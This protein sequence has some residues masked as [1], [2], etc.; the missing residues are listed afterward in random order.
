MYKDCS[1]CFNIFSAEF[2]ESKLACDVSADR[3]MG[4]LQVLDLSAVCVKNISDTKK[5]FDCQVQAYMAENT[6]AS[7]YT[8]ACKEIVEKYGPCKLDGI[9]D[10]GFQ[11]T[12]NEIGLTAAGVGFELISAYQ[13]VHTAQLL[14]SF[15]LVS[16]PPSL[17]NTLKSEELTSDPMPGCFS[18]VLVDPYGFSL[19]DGQRIK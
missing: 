2:D 9:I 16:F 10:Q 7:K 18:V 6:A 4:W 1:S 17:H 3:C 5:R 8:A 19:M 13:M 11:I 15:A 12:A 14:S